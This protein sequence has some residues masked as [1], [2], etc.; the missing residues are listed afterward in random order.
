[1][2]VAIIGAAGSCGRQLAAQLLERAVLPASAR[3]QLVG[4]RGGRGEHEFWGLRAD[5]EDAFEDDA[6][7][8]ELVLDAEDIDAS[9]VVMLAGATVPNDPGK[10][11]DRAALGHTNLRI[12]RQYADVLARRAGA[13]PTVIVQSNPV[14]LGVAV[15]A[16]RLGRHR[17]LGAGAWSDTL[18]LRAEIAAD[19]GVRR[20][21]VHVPVLGQ[22]GDNL[23]PVWSRLQVQGLDEARVADYVASVC[24]GRD[25]AALPTAVREERERMVTSVRNGD[26]DAAYEH[27]RSLPP[28]LRVAVKPFFTH[29][30]SGHTTEIVTARAVADIVAALV[31]GEERLL[32]AQV[33]LDGEWLGIEGV[34]AAPVALGPT[35]WDQVIP[36]ELLEREATAVRAAA[37]A[38]AAATAAL[39]SDPAPTA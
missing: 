23:V 18:R 13:P 29:F 11:T 21:Q 12:F 8:I 36:I 1:M 5:L 19:L 7:E 2:D 39:V 15:F 34:I 35:G 25:L 33:A 3:L 37:A 26:V 10:P 6:P 38:I 17:V 4:H 16:E 27:I 9:L 30:T 28:D 24:S 20:P 32:P 14:E 31:A 22:H